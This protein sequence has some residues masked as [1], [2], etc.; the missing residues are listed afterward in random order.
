MTTIPITGKFSREELVDFFVPLD[1]ALDDVFDLMEAVEGDV[2][3]AFGLAVF[4]KVVPG[5]LFQLDKQTV[6]RAGGGE[7]RDAIAAEEDGRALRE[8][9]VWRDAPVLVV[10]ESS[11]DFEYIRSGCVKSQNPRRFSQLAR[12]RETVL[13]STDDSGWRYLIVHC[14]GPDPLLVSTSF[15]TISIRSASSAPIKFSRIARMIGTMPLD[16]SIE[17]NFD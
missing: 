6:G 7:V 14:P 1:D 3:D 11:T 13:S 10:P 8:R 4:G 12:E 5:A 17:P 15:A 16:Q 2:L 9:S